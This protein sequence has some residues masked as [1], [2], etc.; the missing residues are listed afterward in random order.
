MRIGALEASHAS[1]GAI[2]SGLCLE[3]QP[4]Q[5]RYHRSRR[6][7][8]FES[9]VR[10]PLPRHRP[11]SSRPARIRRPA[12]EARRGVLRPRRQRGLD[13]DPGRE[14]HTGRAA[15][16]TQISAHLRADAC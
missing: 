7:P 14:L 10:P 4:R 16:R 6:P 15:E 11:L 9:H 5:P 1:I 8:V 3:E 2:N 13:A 12:R